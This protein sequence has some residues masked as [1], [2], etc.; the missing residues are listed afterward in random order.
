MLKIKSQSSTFRAHALLLLQPQDHRYF[1]QN[2]YHKS[3]NNNVVV[4]VIV[5]HVGDQGSSMAPYLI[6]QTPPSANSSTKPGVNLEHHSVDPLPHKRNTCHYFSCASN[7]DS[8]FLSNLC[9]LFPHLLLN[10]D[11]LLFAIYLKKNTD[12]SSTL[13]FEVVIKL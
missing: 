11:H 2:T 6:P 10:N 9:F 8:N 12:L 3:W 13:G 5:L 7:E 1:N 4:K